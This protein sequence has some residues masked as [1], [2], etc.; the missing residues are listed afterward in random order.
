MSDATWYPA[1]VWIRPLEVFDALREDE[2]GIDASSKFAVGAAMLTGL[3]V[4]V[5]AIPGTGAGFGALLFALGVALQV[6]FSPF[7][8]GGVL[9][10][11]AR[12]LGG[13][14]A[15]YAQ[16]VS[17]PVVLIGL[18]PLS[19]VLQGVAHRLGGES[20]ALMVGFVLPFG[21]GVVFAALGLVRT[22][23]AHGVATSVLASLLTLFV[24]GLGSLVVVVMSSF[25]DLEGQHAEWE[26]QKARLIARAQAEEAAR[27]G[28]APPQP[29]AAPTPEVPAAPTDGWL[30]DCE[31]VPPG[32]TIEEIGTGRVLGTTPVKL[33]FPNE[34]ARVDLRLRHGTAEKVARVTRGGDPFLI[35]ALPMEAAEEPTPP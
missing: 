24:V 18:V 28:T 11:A 32:A 27:A 10:I 9:W 12:V 30:V 20:V 6:A 34:V 2:L 21:L 8:L 3:L 29:T 17:V 22:L 33:T 1:T 23:G 31:S 16:A 4:A 25:A 7:V 5:G 15:T 35:V 26:E 19:V 14:E 13:K